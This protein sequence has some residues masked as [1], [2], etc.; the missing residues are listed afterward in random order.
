MKQLF[1]FCRLAHDP[2]SVLAAI[3]RLALVGIELALNGGLC[4]SPFRVTDELCI[5]PFADSK[6]WDVPDSLYDSKIAFS[7]VQSL[8]HHAGGL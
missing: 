1:V 5:A 4:I 7:H 2:Q 8:A 6:R 3:H